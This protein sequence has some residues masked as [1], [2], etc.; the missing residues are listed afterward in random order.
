MQ[1]RKVLVVD[2]DEH[3]RALLKTA[4][5]HDYEVFTAVDGIAAIQQ[6]QENIALV[7]SDITMP[8]MNGIQLAERLKW[9]HPWIPIL[10]MTGSAGLASKTATRGYSVI[11]KPFGIRQIMD[12]IKELIPK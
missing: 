5:R 11:K 7:L 4:L 3:V 8:R 12:M 1:K 9:E 6:L 2:D 10:L